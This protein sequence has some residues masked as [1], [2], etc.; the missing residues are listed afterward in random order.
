MQSFIVWSIINYILG[1][2]FLGLDIAFFDDC[3]GE[4]ELIRLKRKTKFYLFFPLW[5][6]LFIPLIVIYLISGRI[7]DL[8]TYYKKLENRYL[9][10]IFIDVYR[11]YNK[12][13][14][15]KAQLEIKEHLSNEEYNKLVDLTYKEH[16]Y[17]TSTCYLDL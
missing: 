15:E 8:W 1:T 10:K 6:F 13:L 14:E 5:G 9:E 12:L 3:R 11:E 16:R 7:V 17:K 2:L 4:K